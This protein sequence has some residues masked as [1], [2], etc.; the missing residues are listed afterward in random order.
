MCIHSD[1]ILTVILP[2]AFLRFSKRK[3]QQTQLEAKKHAIQK[4]DS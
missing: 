1:Y 3:S 4:A 2:R